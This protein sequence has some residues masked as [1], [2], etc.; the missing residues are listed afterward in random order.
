MRWCC[1]TGHGRNSLGQPQRFRYPF[2]HEIV[3]RD[4]AATFDQFRDHIHARRRVIFEPRS[5]RPV[6]RPLREALHTALVVEPFGGTE[7]CVRKSGGVRE[8]LFDGDL[9]LTVRAELRNDVRNALVHPQLAVLH[10]QPTGGGRDRFRRREHVEQRLVG[11]VAEAS[12]VPRS[13]RVARLRPDTPATIRR[14]LPCVRAISSASSFSESMPTSSGDAATN[15]ESIMVLPLV[16]DLPGLYG[17]R[18]RRGYA[19]DGPAVA[20]HAPAVRLLRQH[21]CP[22]A[23]FD[24]R[25]PRNVPFQVVGSAKNARSPVRL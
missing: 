19:G 15:C 23:G 25:V 14:P 18:R 12:R 24:E 11:G 3:E 6:Q 8:Q 13:C 2:A 16:E 20:L 1:S 21:E 17:L 7:R 9:V 10:H 4:V 22:A 5:H